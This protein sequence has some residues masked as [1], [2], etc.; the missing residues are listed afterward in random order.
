[1]PF[2]ANFPLFA[3][4]IT[5]LGGVFSI[6][7][8]T[9]GAYRI[10]LFVVSANVVLN[11]S[12]LIYFLDN[13]GYITYSMGHFPAPWG[14][15]IR[16]SP[17][18]VL[19]ATLI[20][21]VMLLVVI[22]EKEQ[23][24]TTVKK[25]R[26][27]LFYAMLNLT[28]AS[29]IALIYTNDLFTAFVFVE[30]NTLCACGLVMAKENGKTIA[31]SIKYLIMSL[32][33]SGLFLISII[34]IYDLTGHLLMPN[35]A[36]QLQIIMQNEVYLLPV[37]MIVGLLAV[38]IA[39]KSGLFPFHSWQ[40]HAYNSAMNISNAISSSI[41]VKGYIILLIKIFLRVLGL[42]IISKLHVSN[43]LFLFGFLSM[44]L[45]S[46]FAAREHTIKRMLAF[47]SVSYVGYIFLG[48]GMGTT[49]GFLAA[50]FLIISHSLT[51]SMLFIA[52]EGLMVASDNS[53]YFNDL[54]GAAYRNPP[55]AA[56]FIIG[57]LSMIGFPLF[58][59][60]VGKYMLGLAGMDSV[61]KMWFVLVAIAITTV[62]NGVYYLR[63]IIAIFTKDEDR[64]EKY[65]NS[66]RFI[67]GLVVFII[68]NLSVGIFYEPV[69]A[70]IETG[71]NFI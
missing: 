10:N 15:E 67:I 51:K 31:A 38:G 46:V 21:V 32:L 33:G 68:L 62:L 55:A 70:F 6:I 35:V 59:G 7:A 40:P 61:N 3:L 43:I 71:L 13:P 53:K 49:A 52:T 18:E 28:Q 1:M 47:S 37:T 58:S 63:A 23:I 64:C 50:I 60:F 26:K 27:N 66:K 2:V 44:I 54:R 45:G 4:I 22:S 36:E 57:A 34:L 30:I 29:L 39:I 17:V 11:G 69:A 48:M 9:N 25:R 24:F 41:I 42:D 56:G 12:L 65:K 20:A 16:F 19:L 5:I 14:N 8:T